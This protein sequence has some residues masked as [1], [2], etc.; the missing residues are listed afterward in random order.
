MFCVTEG[1]LRVRLCGWVI[2]CLEREAVANEATN[3]AYKSQPR[4]FLVN[5]FTHVHTPFNID[6]ISF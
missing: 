2:L 5:R 6:G 3:R 4:V 1:M